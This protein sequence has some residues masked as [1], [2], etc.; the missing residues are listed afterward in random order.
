[1]V[2]VLLMTADTSDV[3]GFEVDTR[4]DGLQRRVLE[5]FQRELISSG[6]AREL[7]GHSVEE[8]LDA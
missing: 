2:D 5:A 8:L 7:L 6:R 1:M 3:M 4:F